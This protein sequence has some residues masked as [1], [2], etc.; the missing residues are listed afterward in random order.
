M[1]AGVY[2]INVEQGASW[3]LDLTWKDDAGTP[4]NLT[5][6]SARMQIRKAYSSSSLLSLTSTA[7][8]I[9]LGGALG[10]LAITASATQTA[11]IA[12]DYS[13]LSVNDGKPCQAMVYDIEVQDGSGTV[14]RLLQGTA[15]IYP[16]ATK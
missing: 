2:N 7:G 4:I 9:A 6:Y 12:I 13:A 10:T 5:G 14:T 15:Y 3:T 1:L 16:E 11:D 8:D